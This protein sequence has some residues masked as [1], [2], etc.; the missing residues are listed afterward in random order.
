[1]LRVR[2]HRGASYRQLRAAVVVVWALLMAFSLFGLMN[3]ATEGYG[4]AGTI[5]GTI[6][7][8]CATF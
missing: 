6:L 3:D 5:L 7:F 8:L 4:L 1:M 2:S